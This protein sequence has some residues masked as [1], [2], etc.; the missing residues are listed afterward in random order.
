MWTFKVIPD[1]GEPFEVTSGSRDVLAWE[2]KTKLTARHLLDKM[3]M[4]ELYKIAHLAATRQGLYDGDYAEF[5][6]TCDI[7][8]K[9]DDDDGDGPADPTRPDH[10]T[11]S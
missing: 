1:D 9:D 8:V 10:T 7:D 4:V 3:P 2:R 6:S 11:G 5:E